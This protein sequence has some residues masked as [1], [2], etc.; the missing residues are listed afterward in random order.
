MLMMVTTVKVRAREMVQ[1]LRAYTAF[2]DYLSSDPSVHMILT[3]VKGPE[4]KKK[5]TSQGL[6][7]VH[8]VLM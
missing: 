5:K 7:K 6:Y 3:T 1:L 4:C 8:Y 2:P